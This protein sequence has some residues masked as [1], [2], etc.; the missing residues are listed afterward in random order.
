MSDIKLIND[1]CLLSRRGVCLMDMS[2][3]A[4]KAQQ[5]GLTQL[6]ELVEKDLQ[7]NK[8]TDGSYFPLVAGI[9]GMQS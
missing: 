2:Q 5:L 3:V 4:E 7:E 6:A 9:Y 1:M 8:I